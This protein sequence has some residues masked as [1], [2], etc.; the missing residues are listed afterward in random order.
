MSNEG[1]DDFMK[2]LELVYLNVENGNT[3]SDIIIE[4]PNK[5]KNISL[6]ATLNEDKYFY[7]DNSKPH[8][9]QVIYLRG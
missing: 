2:K 8:F 3:S 7:W 4:I 6:N 1:L 5:I 9:S